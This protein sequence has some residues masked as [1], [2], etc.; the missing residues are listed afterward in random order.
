MRFYNLDDHKK[1]EYLLKSCENII[2]YFSMKEYQNRAT[3]CI[4]ACW[5]WLKNKE[6]DGEY[7]YDL[8]DDEGEGL[9]SIQYSA[10]SNK[11]KNIWS[12]IID[13]LAYTSRKAYESEGDRYFPEPIALVEDS[14]IEHF[15]ASLNRLT[16]EE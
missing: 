3:F 16:N 11:D 1:I 5:S 10:K 13:A 8:L 12:C 9:V 14:I 15:N 7:L 6:K 2:P 4:E